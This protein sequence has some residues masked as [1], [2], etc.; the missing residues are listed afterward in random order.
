M[1]A[2]VGVIPLSRCWMFLGKPL[3]DDTI[4]GLAW[5]LFLWNLYG[6]LPSIIHGMASG[7]NVTSRIDDKGGFGL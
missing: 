6:A 5:L 3:V 1:W 7:L 4:V 2:A